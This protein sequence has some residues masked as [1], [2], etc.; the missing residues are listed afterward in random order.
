MKRL[1]IAALAAAALLSS[2]KESVDTTV[3]LNTEALSFGYGG[4]QQ[5]LSVR[6]GLDWTTLHDDWITLSPDHGY[7]SESA[8]YMIVTVAANDG[9]PRTGHITIVT[10]GRDNQT[11]TVKQGEDPLVITGTDSFMK[12][13][14]EVQNY[15]ENDK[16]SVKGDIDLAGKTLPHIGKMKCSLDG[17]GCTIKNW[18]AS[19]SLVD[20]LGAGA[21]IKGFVIDAS[22]SIPFRA[23][24]GNFGLLVSN[25]YGTV[26]GITLNAGG[27][28]PALIEGAVGG[29]VGY[30]YAGGMVSD[31]INNG[32]FTYS[33]PGNTAG[34]M[35][36][37][38][39][40]GRV[41][42]SD[43]TTTSIANCENHGKISFTVN[44]NTTNK[45]IY[46]AGVTGSA[47]S[48][49][50]A[51]QCRN[52][53][54]LTL[55]TKGFDAVHFVCGIVCYSAGEVTG[56][57][58]SGKIT[59]LSES[60]S[61]KADGAFR[62]AAAAG[63]S[64]YQG[65]GNGH[66]SACKNSG[67]ITLRAGYSVGKT[68]VGSITNYSGV[69]AGLIGCTFKCNVVGSDNSGKVNF[70]LGAID[71]CTADG[72]NTAT[73]QSCGGIVGSAQGN[74]ETCV[75]EGPIEIE[76]ITS[77]H[78]ATLAKN[79]VFQ[80]G[81]I[82]GGAYNGTDKNNSGITSC[83]N[84]A[85]IHIICDSGQSNNAF[86]GI[87]GWP[88]NESAAQVAV[89]KDCINRGDI[90]VEGYG[91]H[92]IGG[93]HGGAGIMEGC[94]NYGKIWFKSGNS[95]SGIGGLAGYRNFLNTTSCANYGDVV[96]EVALA[97]G[98][99]GLV[100]GAGNTEMTLAGCKVDCKVS[101]PDGAQYASMLIGRMDHNKAGAK[102]IN[103]GTAEAPTKVKGTFGTTVL[104]A[105][106]YQ[107]FIKYPAFNNDYTSNIHFKVAF[108]D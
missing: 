82:T 76:W 11:V 4:G 52:S 63:I 42:G 96:S 43:I 92:R 89:S 103:I 97:W 65:S 15:G 101:A 48:Y 2:C 39:V 3:Y 105:D 23:D 79:I 33:G 85:P 91:K 31:C 16:I 94:T 50:K 58:N 5:M 36:F 10:N 9:D 87:S 95:N 30:T 104:N 80:A 66:F 86:G 41:Y 67:E 47:N 40:S 88:G 22:C 64:G 24:K 38:G 62:A 77:T 6:S 55:S 19:E 21:I 81:G 61:G 78:D 25:N 34:S 57:E 93:I 29:I 32:D 59:L 18:N 53:G 17:K 72:Y 1:M 27:T 35:Y 102:D 28:V 60:A 75:N 71:N 98:V 54:D 99:G 7:G 70:K 20:T 14:A 73:R 44:D 37:G 69:A 100:G 90:T 84:K 83:E 56:C 49:A 8:Q 46:I 45:S 51:L 12:F 68:T 74:V 13:L 106:N 26:S 108:G 107:S